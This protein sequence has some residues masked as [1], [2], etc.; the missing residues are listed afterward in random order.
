[1]PEMDTSS[2]VDADAKLRAPTHRRGLSG[3]SWPVLAVV[4]AGGVVGAL[5]RYGLTVVFAYR[6]GA[7]PW[8]TFGINVAGCLLIGVLMALL[9]EVWIG[10]RLLRPFLGVGVLGGFTTFSTYTLDIVQAVDTGAVPVALACLAGTVIAALAAVWVGVAITGWVI[11]LR[12][13]AILAPRE[14]ES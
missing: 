1:M 3:G 12:R 11:G 2:L 14:E 13:Q 10:R 6:P 8:A 4:S 5:S 9:A 7:F